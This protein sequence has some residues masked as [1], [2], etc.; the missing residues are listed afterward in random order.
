MV[1]H[2]LCNVNGEMDMDMNIITVISN[3]NN[4]AARRLNRHQ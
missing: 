2:V 1:Y 3:I 4:H